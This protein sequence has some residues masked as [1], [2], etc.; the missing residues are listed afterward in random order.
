M[1]KQEAKSLKTRTSICKA[2]IDCLVEFGYGETTIARV[3]QKA[4]VS[5]GAL[6]HH[7]PSKEHLMTAT[8]EFLL[9]RTRSRRTRVPA[10]DDGDDT[11]RVANDLLTNWTVFINTPSYRALLE[12][13]IAARTDEKLH[14]QIEDTL[15]AY[16]A[17]SVNMM[18][19]TYE[20][21]TGR[22]EDAEL[23]PWMSNIFFRGL[24]IQDQYSADPERQQRMVERWIELVAPLLRLR[25]K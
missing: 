1:G 24:L 13:L 12:I 4:E 3:V 10:L 19:E 18:M 6:L 25:S 8:A 22:A 15:H 9:G 21:A 11:D 17:Q 16:H 2:T 23:L 5:N 7:F 20:S 14:A